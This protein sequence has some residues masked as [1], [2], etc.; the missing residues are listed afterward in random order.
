MEKIILGFAGEIASGKG[1]ACDF[2]IK[3]YNAGY[4][5]YSTILRDIAD[6]LFLEQNRENLQGLSTILREKFGQDLL[7]NIMAKQ[8]NEDDSQ[9]VCI[10]GIRRMEDIEYLAKLPNFIMINIQADMKT[11]YE[12]IIARS[13][14]TDDQQKTFEQFKKDHENENEQT[15]AQVAA[16]AQETIT[17]DGSHDELYEKIIALVNKYNKK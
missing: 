10:D 1:T 13:E 14:N 16:S 17:N 12:R 6:R 7:A 5:R 9:I 8:V 3:K 4:Y 11:R 2:L 15:I